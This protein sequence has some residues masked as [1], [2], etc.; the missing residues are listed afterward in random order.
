[1]GARQTTHA[2]RTSSAEES[3]RRVV[4]SH[5]H[6]M[7]R[8]DEVD[9]PSS[10]I[11]P[12][13]LRGMAGSRKYLL[14]LDRNMKVFLRASN[15]PGLEYRLK[16]AG[17]RTFHDLLTTDR[18]TLEARGFTAIMAQRL[19]S[20]VSE[21]IDRQLQRTEEERQPFR[22][23]R[24][25]Q[26]LKTEPSE[27][28]KDNPNYQKRNVKR[29]KPME[30]S[31][32]GILQS[33]TQ[34]TT[35]QTQRPSHVRLM[36]ESDLQLQHLLSPPS[37]VLPAD[38]STTAVSGSDGS[39]D[40]LPTENCSRVELPPETE[41]PP[42]GGISS[43]LSPE[44]QSE[45]EF[46]PV[47]SRLPPEE[48]GQKVLGIIVNRPQLE[49][50]P[51]RHEPPFTD[52]DA[53]LGEVSSEEELSDSGGLDETDTPT[54]LAFGP[55]LQRSFSVPADFKLT[56]EEPASENHVVT[57]IRAFSCPSSLASTS[58]LP[59]SHSTSVAT[60]IDTLRNSRSVNELYC[61][62]RGLSRHTEFPHD[63]MEVDKRGAL[64]AVVDVLKEHC[65]VLRVAEVCCQLMHHLCR[66][67]HHVV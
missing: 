43:E 65:R 37:Q 31:G 32:K 8:R 64:E 49:K 57:H 3:H 41:F 34:H 61:T 25:G 23:V 36:N 63:A 52:L 66:G 56:F 28:M 33:E 16:L 62:L 40:E 15:L 48:A 45:I 39:G 55:H 29:R 30:D 4:T 51:S 11:P 9:T 5:H 27:T 67:T 10:L 7:Y 19:M 22:L 17:Y 6:S 12:S 21:Y 46:P 13:R 38:A 59:Q 47:D 42:E 14:S 44:E 53:L 24:R 54:D 35:R 2:L 20:A 60:L 26:R 58:K 50:P 18:A 1:M